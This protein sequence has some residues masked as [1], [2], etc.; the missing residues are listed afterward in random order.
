MTLL[1]KTRADAIVIAQAL[2]LI[3]GG[4]LLSEWTSWIVLPAVPALLLGTWWDLRIGLGV[5]ALLEMVVLHRHGAL[6]FLT[7]LSVVF[8]WSEHLVFR[9]AAGLLMVVAGWLARM[10][11]ATLTTAWLAGGAMLISVLV[12]VDL[13]KNE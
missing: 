7:M 6:A 2:S 1:R 3:A 4:A 8:L 12:E 11:V 13:W 9:A 10:Q 5:G